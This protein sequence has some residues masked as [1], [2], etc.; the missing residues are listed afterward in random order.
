MSTSQHWCFTSFENDPPVFNEA[1][2][3][4]L[5]RGLEV[6]PETDKEHWQCYVEFGSRKRFA[7]VKKLLG[8]HVHLET[9][10]G[11]AEQAADYCKKD[12]VFEEYGTLSYS[13]QGR[14]EALGQAIKVVSEGGSIKAIAAVTPVAIILYNRGIDRLIKLKET[15]VPAWRDVKVEVHWGDSG[16]GKTRQAMERFPNLYR[17]RVSEGGP[18]WWDGYEGQDVI[19]IDDFANDIRLTSLLQTLDGY[20]LPLWI[21]GGQTQARW[22]RALIT[23]NLDPAG[24]YPT[25]NPRHR[26]ALQRRITTVTK[27]EAPAPVVQEEFLP[28]AE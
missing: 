11:S 4:Y 1:E 22:T 19:L 9:R 12:E 24:W 18:E 25:A 21:K 20:R 8:D 15:E 28:E 5:V 27:Y 10:R 2:M 16:T 13:C 7:T 6:C 3:T 17:F 23:S 14:A 26:A